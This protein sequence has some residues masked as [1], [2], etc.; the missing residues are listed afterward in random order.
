LIHLKV[1]WEVSEPK[2][3]TATR[4][5]HSQKEAHKGYHRN[6]ESFLVHINKNT[7]SSISDTQ[8][9]DTVKIEET[10]CSVDGNISNACKE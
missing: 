9:V 3:S 5:Q 8:R 10:L 1:T 4:K 7:F 6:S 2:S